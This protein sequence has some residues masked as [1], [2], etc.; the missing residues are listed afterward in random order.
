MNMLIAFL[1]LVVA[2]VT[3]VALVSGNMFYFYLVGKRYI[4]LHYI[5][6]NLQ[7]GDELK[8]LAVT[9]VKECGPLH[10]LDNETIAKLH[11]PEEIAKI[12]A[13]DNIMVRMQY[14]IYRCIYHSSFFA[15][16]LISLTTMLLSVLHEMP[17]RSL[18]HSR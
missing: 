15:H 5:T 8:A 4:I 14:T 13:D 2:T 10:H 1:L 7:D 17:V 11:I 16:L 18:S 9:N 3:V 6:I 12:N